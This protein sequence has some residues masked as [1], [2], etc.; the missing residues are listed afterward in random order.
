MHHKIVQ[1]GPGLHVGDYYAAE[2]I[3]DG[4][5]VSQEPNTVE[6]Y[7]LS[8]VRIANKDF[9]VGEGL[10]KCACDNKLDISW[11]PFCSEQY[12]IS[13]KIE[14]YFLVSVPIVVSALPNRNL[15][16]FPYS[17]LTAWRTMQ[18]TVGYRTWIGRPVHVNHENSDDSKAKGVILDASLEPFRDQWAVMILKAFDRSKDPQ[19]AKQVRQRHKIGHSMGCLVEQT[20]CSV[21]SC[22]FLSDGITT[23]EHIAGGAG[24]GQIIRQNLVY[25]LLRSWSGVESSVVADPAWV[26]A[27]SQQFIDM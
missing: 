19:L 25:E 2:T 14:D 26:C 12:Q 22:R 4:R 3:H 21:P 24:K 18:G 11:L 16:A 9:A 27:L 20:E 23:C 17:E 1:A 15:D 7:R 5:V 13:P 6:G 8:K 10:D